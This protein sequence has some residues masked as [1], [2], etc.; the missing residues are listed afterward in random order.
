MC[1]LA[2]L[3]D[4]SFVAKLAR[5]GCVFVYITPISLATLI[6]RVN[7]PHPQTQEAGKQQKVKKKKVKK[8]TT[9]AAMSGGVVVGG[10]GGE[11]HWNDLFTLPE[12]EGMV[13]EAAAVDST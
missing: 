1:G 12:R 7:V 4:V 5:W 3:V 11:K 10:G 6:S 2:A 13:G 8:V 9:A